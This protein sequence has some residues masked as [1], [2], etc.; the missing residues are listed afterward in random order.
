MSDI[1]Q[2]H[3]RTRLLSEKEEDQDW[4][5]WLTAQQAA[6]LSGYDIQPVRRLAYL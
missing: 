3:L 1:L 2:I 6:T 5:S 4:Y